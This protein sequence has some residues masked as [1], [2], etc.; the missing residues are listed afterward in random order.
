MMVDEADPWTSAD[1]AN[2]WTQQEAGA[3]VQV[4]EQVREERSI[5][6][7]TADILYQL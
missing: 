1:F 4:D 3:W 7:G 6:R 5:A 2:A